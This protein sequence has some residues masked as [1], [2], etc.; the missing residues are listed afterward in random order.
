M[1]AI[2]IR[3]D[4]TDRYFAILKQRDFDIS[5]GCFE[6]MIANAY[7]SQVA[8]CGGDTDRTMSAHAQIASVIEEDDAGG[9]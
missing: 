7:L 5:N 1:R 6:A 3:V 9:G 2:T 8:E 4:V